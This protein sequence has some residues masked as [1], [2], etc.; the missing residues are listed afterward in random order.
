MTEQLKCD[1]QIVIWE[2]N[3]NILLINGF[4][5]KGK[6]KKLGGDVTP[7]HAA[8]KRVMRDAH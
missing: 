6:G 5:Y 1:R 8:N 2:D 7:L 4:N 3:S